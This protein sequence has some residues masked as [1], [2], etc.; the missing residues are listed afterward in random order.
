[1]VLFP[2]LQYESMPLCLLT[3]VANRIGKAFYISGA[4]RAVALNISK[5]FDK[6]GLE[7]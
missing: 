6:A 7:L 5:T 2:D 4:T 1:M 3:V